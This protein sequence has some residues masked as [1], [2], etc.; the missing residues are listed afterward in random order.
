MPAA[1]VVDPLPL[2]RIGLRATLQSARIRVEGEAARAIEGA[3]LAV[4]RHADLLIVGEPEPDD[5]AEAIRYA[6]TATVT[7]H[8][9][10]LVSRLTRAGV[11]S[12]LELGVRG[13]LPRATSGDELNDSIHRVLA[14]ERVM[15]PSLAWMLHEL[16]VA[17]DPAHASGTVALTPRERAVLTVLTSGASN[18]EIADRLSMSLPTVR[19]HL[20]RMYAKLGVSSRLEAVAKA[21]SHG[22]T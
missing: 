4:E 12:L 7:M 20:S 8:V 18:A 14:G 6:A 1:V 9:V 19:T 11:S 5:I 10:V 2:L 16:E 22:L 3:G 17:T 13:F 15:S 21:F